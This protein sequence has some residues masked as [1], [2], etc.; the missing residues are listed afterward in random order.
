MSF[1]TIIIYTLKYI[2][3][4]DP[5][6]AKETIKTLEIYVRHLWLSPLKICLKCAEEVMSFI[7]GMTNL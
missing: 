7:L 4:Q 6:E 1:S 3:N 2:K 5:I